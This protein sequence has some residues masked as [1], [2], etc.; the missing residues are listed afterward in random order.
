MPRPAPG[1]SRFAAQPS[2]G[3]HAVDKVLR[4]LGIEA[5]AEGFTRHI[6]KRNFLLADE[7]VAVGQSNLLQD[8]FT[9]FL[10]AYGGGPRKQVCP[11][12][13]ALDHSSR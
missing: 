5:A 3:F 12:A 13:H 1:H 8:F 10:E 11:P 6:L 7:P 9:I 2:C 4:L